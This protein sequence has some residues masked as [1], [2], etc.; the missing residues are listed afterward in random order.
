[1]S[2]DPVPRNPL[3]LDLERPDEVAYWVQRT[4]RPEEDLREAV[5]AVGPKV[6][7]VLRYLAVL[8]GVSDA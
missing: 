6:M 1:V 5:A 4:N 2:D 7:K 8:D 3:Q